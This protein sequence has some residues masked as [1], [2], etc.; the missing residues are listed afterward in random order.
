LLVEALELP[1]KRAGIERFVAAYLPYNR[2]IS[3]LLG[4]LGYGNRR[5][6]DGLVWVEKSL[7]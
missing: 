7:R 4:E 3:D 1:A 2:A 6:D 5:M